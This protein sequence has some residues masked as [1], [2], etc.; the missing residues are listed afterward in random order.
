MNAEFQIPIAQC[1]EEAFLWSHQKSSF[2]LE[3]AI[4]KE[5]LPS[6]PKHI[7]IA[8]KTTVWAEPVSLIVRLIGLAKDF[9]SL[10]SSLSNENRNKIGP[11]YGIRFFVL[12]PLDIIGG[13][14]ASIMRI[15][16][17]IL[18]M[19]SP[20]LAV[21]GWIWA[22]RLEEKSL[23]LQTWVWEKLASDSLN[24]P[25]RLRYGSIYPAKAICYLG[26]DL[27][28]RLNSETLEKSEKE[29]LIN[30]TRRVFLDLLD[31]MDE[32][33]SENFRQELAEELLY[34]ICEMSY[35]TDG[36]YFVFQ[37]ERIAT[38][39]YEAIKQ[40]IIPRC[41]LRA[42][43]R[44]KDNV[45][46]PLLKREEAVN[47]PKLETKKEQISSNL[48]KLQA[49]FVSAWEFGSLEYYARA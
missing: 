16:S 39:D 41:K 46:T 31:S 4:K 6:K 48:L 15:A 49:L 45:V 18:G 47:N 37:G 1:Y 38:N 26:N 28:L 40:K 30:A 36:T 12:T 21:H 22:E 34:C 32:L 27:C 33:N 29:A 25:D 13:A 9:S 11:Y 5:K 3:Q 10:I 17:A 43:K 24:T 20:S 23:K 7:W 8:I 42:L 14:I 44:I 19:A 2:L 35:S